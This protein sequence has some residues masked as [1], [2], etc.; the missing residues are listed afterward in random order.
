MRYV[1]MRCN[2]NITKSQ[3]ELPNSFNNTL[4]QQM[5]KNPQ[6]FHQNSLIDADH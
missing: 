2:I 6:T 3:P 1:T 4:I 5:L